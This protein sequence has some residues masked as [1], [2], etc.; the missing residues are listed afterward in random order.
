[1]EKFDKFIQ[2]HFNLNIEIDNSI[3]RQTLFIDK[4]LEL[5]YKNHFFANSKLQILLSEMMLIFGYIA[6]LIYILI[7]NYKLLFIVLMLSFLA[8]S[9]ILMIITHTIE[10]NRIKFLINHIQIFLICFSLNLKA[11]FICYYYNSVSDDSHMELLRVIIYD[12]VSTNLFILVRHEGNIGINIFYYLLNLATI[13]IAQVKSNKN[14]FYY[15]EAM[16][17]V[18]ISIIFYC[19][20][21]A[22][23]YKMRLLFAE[24]YKIGKFYD[25]TID[26]INGLNAYHSNIKNK[27][28][29][30][31]NEKF[32]KHFEEKSKKRKIIINYN[33]NLNKEQKEGISDF[34]AR[35]DK[36]NSNLIKEDENYLKAKKQN[37]NKY[38]MNRD[39]IFND[40]LNTDRHL[41]ENDV[42]INNNIKGNKNYNKIEL[43]SNTN[44]N[45]L[46]LPD[47]KFTSL[48]NDKIN[49]KNNYLKTNQIDNEL[50]GKINE[51]QYNNELFYDFLKNLYK[52]EFLTIENNSM[53]MSFVNKDNRLFKKSNFIN[54][55]KKKYSIGFDISQIEIEDEKLESDNLLY[56]LENYF[57]N[58]E[59]SEF[60]EDSINIF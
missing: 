41:K 1:M 48:K 28:L 38:D 42:E 44:R 49:F 10:N 6:S 3:F 53:N 11:L 47:K 51:A 30:Y 52:Y 50:N 23:D 37:E 36:A 9:I 56:Y 57:I 27:K 19:F 54:F 43:N 8:I 29:I 13:I 59:K 5:L 21:K 40:D 24:K 25:Y 39:L 35:E 18:F 33:E 12:F 34:K 58:I 32:L 20:R 4:N 17:S 22:W 46:E 45:L 26:F 31:L 15:L 16:T 7:A 2:E 55:K 60:K 14:N